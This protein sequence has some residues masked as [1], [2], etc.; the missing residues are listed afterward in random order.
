MRFL[1][2]PKTGGCSF[3]STY[4]VE[5]LWHRSIRD[6]KP[7]NCEKI[8][9]IVRNPY[10]RFVS[11]FYHYKNINHSVWRARDSDTKMHLF[12]DPNDFIKHLK[13]NDP[14][15]IEEFKKIHF[16]SIVEFLTKDDGTIYEYLEIL[17]FEELFKNESN[18]LNGRLSEYVE[19]TEESKTFIKKC[20]SKDFNFLNFFYLGL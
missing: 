20:Y 5:T 1:H 4:E 2:I 16:L 6:I 7:E 10:D 11:A 18:V 13:N 8:I 19:L 14:I 15:A 17:I 12:K 9:T 3:C